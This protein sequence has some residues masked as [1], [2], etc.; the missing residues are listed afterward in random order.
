[1]K[2]TCRWITVGFLVC[3][4]GMTT[5]HRAWA[6][7]SAQPGPHAAN[8]KLVNNGSGIDQYT[9]SLNWKYNLLTV[10]GRGGLD[11]PIDL[12]YHSGIGCEQEASW[13][14]LGF[15]LNLG[16]IERSIVYIPDDLFIYHVWGGVMDH[17][18][19]GFL[20]DDNYQ[21]PDSFLNDGPDMWTVA[22]SSVGSG[23]S[24][25]AD[26]SNIFRS[27]GTPYGPS[28]DI[29]KAAA[30]SPL[31]ANWLSQYQRSRGLALKIGNQEYEPGGS[32]DVNVDF[33]KHCYVSPRMG[34]TIAGRNY[35]YD[36]EIQLAFN[37]I[38]GEYGDNSGQCSVYVYKLPAGSST[39]SVHGP[40]SVQAANPVWTTTGVSISAGDRF[41]LYT[42]TRLF[43][44]ERWGPYK[45]DYRVGFTDWDGYL[46]NPD[47]FTN[48]YYLWHD[49]FT[50]RIESFRIAD[51][52]GIVYD[53]SVVDYV[54]AHNRQPSNPYEVK[55]S[56][57]YGMSYKLTSIL[58]HDY[59]DMDA[60]GIP[61]P[62]DLGSWVRLL[63]DSIPTQL[64]YQNKSL[65]TFDS[66]FSRLDP[67]DDVQGLD[68]VWQR[69]YVYYPRRLET[70]THVLEFHLSPRLDNAGFHGHTTPAA[71]RPKRLD[72]LVLSSY[73]PAG[74]TRMRKVT[75][76]FADV[77]QRPTS[78]SAW[79]DGQT[80]A[81]HTSNFSEYGTQREA[82]D[83]IGKL[84]LLSVTESSPTGNSLP[85]LRFRYDTNPRYDAQRWDTPT[86]NV[87]L[88]Y[89]DKDPGD[90]GTSYYGQY[91]EEDWGFYRTGF[92]AKPGDDQR[93]WSV[94][95]F[96][97][98]SGA[99]EVLTWE[100]NRYRWT[101]TPAEHPAGTDR[102]EYAPGH[103]IDY[104]DG[105]QRGGV[106]LRAHS[107]EGG[108]QTDSARI[109]SY[110]EGIATKPQSPVKRAFFTGRIGN[111]QEVGYR[112]VSTQLKG[113]PASQRTTMY[114][115]N[116]SALDSDTS[117]VTYYHE[118]V[119]SVDPRESYPDTRENEYY[120][121]EGAKRGL[122]YK[123]DALD[124]SG[125]TI[126][127]RETEYLFDV[128]A[129]LRVEMPYDLSRYTYLPDGH[130][131]SIWARPFKE[132]TKWFD[133]SGL[134]P[135]TFTRLFEYDT[136][137]GLLAS[138]TDSLGGGIGRKEVTEY[139]CTQDGSLTSILAR[140][141]VLDL[142][143][144]K[145]V[146]QVSPGTQTKFKTKHEYKDFGQGRL[147]PWHRYDYRVI[148]GN[149]TSAQAVNFEYP[150]VS[151]TE[152]ETTTFAA[153]DRYG[154]LLLEIDPM[155]KKTSY[156]WGYAGSQSVLEAVNADTGEV[157]YNGFEDG[158][159]FDGWTA[160]L[161]PGSVSISEGPPPDG[162]VALSSTR[163]YSGDYSAHVWDN[164]MLQN[165]A[166]GP[167]RTFTAGSL[168]P[169]KYYV[170]S[171][172][173]YK[174]P[175]EAV[176]RTGLRVFTPTSYDIDTTVSPATSYTWTRVEVVFRALNQEMRIAAHVGMHDSTAYFDDLRIQPLDCQ[177]ET[178]AYDRATGQLQAAF[179]ANNV[180][181]ERNYFDG[182]GRLTSVVDP[183][184]NTLARYVYAYSRVDTAAFNPN[185]PNSVKEIRY[186]SATDST[187]TVTY[188]DG[189]GREVQK[190]VSVNANAKIVSGCVYNPA[191]QLAARTKS[192]EISGPLGNMA[193]ETGFLPTGWTAG[194]ALAGGSLNAY[195]DADG[196]GPNCS[197]YPYT[198]Y[199]YTDDPLRRLD[200]IGYP[201]PTWKTGSGRTTRTA[202]L[203]NTASDVAGWA[204]QTLTKTRVTD[205]GGKVS[206]SYKDR[207]GRV[208]QTQADSVDADVSRFKTQF[209]HDILGNQTKAIRQHSAAL[210][211]TTI[212]EYNAFSRLTMEKSPDGGMTRYVYDT[213]GNL[214]FV[215]D[216][217][218]KSA[219]QFVYYKYD[220]HGRK[221]E[222]GVADDTT[223]FTQANAST[224][225]FPSSSRSAKFIF[226]YDS[227]GVP[228]SRGRLSSWSDSAGT[229]KR[230]YKYD[231]VGRIIEDSV[232]LEGVANKLVYSYDWQG[233]LATQATAVGPITPTIC[234]KYDMA[235][236]LVGVGTSGAPYRY[237]SLA[238]WPTGAIR[239]Q[240][241]KATAAST[242]QTLDYRY[243]P[244]DW[245][246]A[247]NDTGTVSGLA[248]GTGDHFAEALG[249]LG[250]FTG[251]PDT[252]GS[253]LSTL[254]GC[255]EIANYDRRGRLARWHRREAGTDTTGDEI[256]RYD[257][258]GNILFWK[259]AWSTA[260]FHHLYYPGS[261]KLRRITTNPQDTVT[262][263]VWW[264]NGHLRAEPTRI[265]QTDYRN[266]NN[267]IEINKYP[268]DPWAN[269]LTFAYDAD[270]QRVKKV[271]D[272]GYRCACGEPAGINIENDT[273][274]GDRLR[275]KTPGLA[276]EPTGKGADHKSGVRPAAGNPG[277]CVC[278][279][280]TTTQ[281]LYTY[282]GRL[283]REY[284][285]NLPKREYLYAGG[286]RIGVYEKIGTSFNLHY[287]VTDHLGSTR[288]F[289]DS[290]G[291]VK[292]TYDYYPYGTERSS[293]VTTDT[294][295]RFT[296]KELD[297][298]DI[299][300]Y[301]FGAR[302]LNGGTLRFNSVDP[303]ANK[304][305]G[306]SPYCYTLDNPLRNVD[307]EGEWVE[308][309]LDVVSFGM[310]ARD[311][312]KSPSWSNAGWVALDLVS[313]ALPLVP[314]V[315]IAQHAGKIDDAVDLARRVDE[316][317]D[318]AV[319]AARTT[320]QTTEA[321][322]AGKATGKVT[323]DDLKAARKDFSTVKSDFWKNE[324]S[325]NGSKY[326]PDNI[327][328]MEK[329]KPP[330]GD[331]G[332]PV[333]LHH[334]TPLS[335]GGTNSIENLEIMTRQAHRLGENYRTNHPKP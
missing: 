183:D 223:R 13:V 73:G 35:N 59:V 178:F 31:G 279:S 174:G 179:N 114:F 129:S 302:Y 210:A 17:E 266:L 218:R 217:V 84:T 172:W 209:T 297:D 190:Q 113:D 269:T 291:L 5:A 284:V 274:T 289:I 95:N 61:S 222:E 48:P 55:M 20:F 153:Y 294:K 103:G 227:T 173:V 184:G 138:Q 88:D 117:R 257:R 74:L 206:Y 162:N 330:I 91:F 135:V 203:S 214:R 332:M 25:V 66:D 166:D 87:N 53:F 199:D 104:P 77:T 34:D 189:L 67:R 124:A 180:A 245:L 319:D 201:D 80:L 301:Y 270:R 327:S 128:R 98:P 273:T 298:E 22:L 287:F 3:V 12:T 14:G 275:A 15:G 226:R 171:A 56:V 24:I 123:Q 44:F 11:F 169:G 51:P 107:V 85:S 331:D 278:R 185:S 30:A 244:R 79:V 277:E 182:F 311:F 315:G 333:E 237:D 320:E 119:P 248:T 260:G 265:F 276:E 304:Y 70:P 160:D 242:C 228:F 314:A 26:S 127:A 150:L 90:D 122:P 264:A 41:G 50:P 231:Q 159:L 7:A 317:A 296:G 93:A 310:S 28:G 37:D 309:A 262:D 68:T 283:L 334:R 271:Y 295:Q 306:W 303:L 281:Y 108:M 57:A 120:L 136:V 54:K 40:Y 255:T 101:H 165:G 236:R 8:F 111:S 118:P 1:M 197:G 92:N 216:A 323:G 89:S 142:L 300:Q 224:Q 192:I 141:H 149:P 229:Y 313:V 187:V 157:S 121:L 27:A 251:D 60:N 316:A 213:D 250:S 69:H 42:R 235:N 131:R 252:V 45:I 10:P 32:S 132:V 205:E 263:Y 163:K 168:T 39:W 6:E 322:E 272:V 299:R 221:I 99:L 102:I 167:V 105:A 46:A 308:T 188:Y 72:S 194:N 196:P 126:F 154:N 140:K 325:T 143:Y 230:F 328:R 290:T 307:R 175:D 96:I 130:S 164:T 38:L 78:F 139:L 151:P 243:N 232:R 259:Q 249:Y 176:Y 81:W 282:D 240:T 4:G 207:L 195:Y 254:P 145:E 211:D 234:Y 52:S 241:F 198:Q 63:Y 186:R 29:Y 97:Y 312:W 2:Q 204:G 49:G 83:S 75:F 335:K 115:T 116:G 321:V 112:S 86:R 324:A 261:N 239:T 94:K 137:N 193:F 246:V 225:P 280:K 147:Y 106:R 233:N 200:D 215:M 109:Y 18:H 181:A 329:G 19:D 293:T 161:A 152:V 82:V 133:P 191:G 125:D 110:G 47:G 219:N 170:F 58:S 285:N 16:S 267:F 326:S 62:G 258:A 155:G 134:N 256:Y 65:K 146:H 177:M 220:V 21:L 64:E 247:I 43:E 71:M 202:Y 268:P 292:S 158:V 9:G 36:G 286:R 212:W 23:L 148:V 238:Y 33:A 144:T 305:P 100:S 208:V 76:N 288:S 318:K 253:K 156:L